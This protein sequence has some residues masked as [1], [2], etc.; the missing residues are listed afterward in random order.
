MAIRYF[1]SGQVVLR[2]SHIANDLLRGATFFPFLAIT[3]S[4]I[5]KSLAI[6]LLDSSRIVLFLSGALASLSV[7]SDFVRT[8]Q[9]KE[10]GLFN[11]D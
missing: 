9:G 1:S 6:A 10:R 2:K 4:I 7:L 3:G 5:D 11:G 8:A